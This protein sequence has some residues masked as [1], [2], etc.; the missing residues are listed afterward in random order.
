[1]GVSGSASWSYHPTSLTLV[2]SHGLI[3][4]RFRLWN[5]LM[6]ILRDAT[7]LVVPHDN[8]T[9]LPAFGS[10]SW[11]YHLTLLL[12][13]C[14]MIISLDAPAF[15]SAS[16]LYDLTLL[17]LEMP[18]Y[19]SLDAFDLPNFVITSLTLPRHHPSGEFGRFLSCTD[20]VCPVETWSLKFAT[21]PEAFKRRNHRDLCLN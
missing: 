1:M 6:I 12:W 9:W 18:H 2:A 8:I 16:C 19:I 5:W 7:V 10:V 13:Q 15:G 20:N 4:W 11:S 3:T 14:V 17:P 21:V